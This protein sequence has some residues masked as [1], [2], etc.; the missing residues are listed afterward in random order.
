M[1]S[2]VFLFVFYH[3]D[4]I[5]YDHACE[6]CVFMVGKGRVREGGKEGGREGGR[7]GGG[8]RWFSKPYSREKLILRM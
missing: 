7:E 6:Y 5:M 8:E 2:L 4:Y 3:N 1:A